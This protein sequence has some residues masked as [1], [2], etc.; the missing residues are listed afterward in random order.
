MNRIKIMASFILVLVVIIFYGNIANATSSSKEIISFNLPSDNAQYSGSWPENG[1]DGVIYNWN[2]CLQQEPACSIPSNVIPVSEIHV[3][4]PFGTST[5]SLIPTLITNGVSISP[6]SGLVQDFTHP[7]VYTV[8][9]EDNSIQKYKV[10]ITVAGNPAREIT[11]F[12]LTLPVNNQENNGVILI[13]PSLEKDGVITGTNIAVTVPFGTDVTNL[14]PSIN[15][16]GASVIPVNGVPQDFTNPVIYKVTARDPSLT[17]DYTVT[18]TVAPPSDITTLT[19]LISEAQNKYNN[20]VEGN[21][22]G[23]YPAPLKADLQSAINAASIINRGYPQS[24]VNDLITYLNTTITKFDTGVI[25][26]PVVASSIAVI[27]SSNRGGGRAAYIP[28]QINI[29]TPTVD[30]PPVEI[31]VPTIQT[32]IIKDTPITLIKTKSPKKVAI[33]VKKQNPL[34][35]EEVTPSKINTENNLSAS[36]ASAP[37]SSGL[38]SFFNRLF[39]WFK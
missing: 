9:A 37:A 23:Q 29:I 26:V 19:A 21:L 38:V 28:Q 2:D 4:L 16:I 1:I 34:K 39:R 24:V 11:L 7:V 25:P 36:V 3:S 17:R 18:V 22:A 32:P 14:T 10:I 13:S 30:I 31:T 5:T 35:I 27:Q 8:T 15:I 6:A 33:Q 12:S 20:A